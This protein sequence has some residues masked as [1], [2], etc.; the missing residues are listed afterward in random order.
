MRTN[1]HFF[2]SK[3]LRTKRKAYL[4]KYSGGIISGYKWVISFEKK[5]LFY[6]VAVEIDLRDY[7]P[8]SK[9]KG[10]ELNIL[11]RPWRVPVN[12]E[13]FRANGVPLGDCKD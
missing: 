5:L 12:R 9:R 6:T 7:G 4:E 11:S 13:W 1:R 8:V 3:K 2:Q 10:Y